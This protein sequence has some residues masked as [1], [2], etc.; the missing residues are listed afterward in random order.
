[1]FTVPM[2]VSGNFWLLEVSLFSTFHVHILS[3]LLW[4]HAKRKVI[5]SQNVQ[6]VRFDTFT[7]PMRVSGNFWLL[8]VSPFS[9][10]LVHISSNLLWI[11]AKRKVIFS[12]NEQI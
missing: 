1:M 12:Q 3:N 9:T 2:R 10:F 5:F 7:V 11:R 8:E 4:I 6:I